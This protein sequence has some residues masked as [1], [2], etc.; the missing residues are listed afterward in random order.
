[1]FSLYRDTLKQNL[2]IFSC[3]YVTALTD[4]QI[5][6]VE[7]P[8]QEGK[9][10]MQLS[11]YGQTVPAEGRKKYQRIGPGRGKNITFS[12]MKLLFVLPLL[13]DGRL[14]DDPGPGLRR[15]GRVASLSENTEYRTTDTGC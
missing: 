1:M 10:F 5:C 2:C 12:F 11:Q 13:D 3:Q 14:L 15:A 9:L 4:A 7:T 6:N 8:S